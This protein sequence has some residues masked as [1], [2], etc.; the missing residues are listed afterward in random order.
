[1]RRSWRSKETE[2]KGGNE[3]QLIASPIE[4]G[5]SSILKM[6]RG[7][8][9]RDGNNKIGGDP[10]HYHFMPVFDSVHGQTTGCVLQIRGVRQLTKYR[11]LF[12][13]AVV[14][15]DKRKSVAGKW[16]MI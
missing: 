7:P 1:M 6:G 14:N 11:E 3:F 8:H 4:C 13:I 15:Q 16:D 12:C 5:G 9:L 2:D 10:L